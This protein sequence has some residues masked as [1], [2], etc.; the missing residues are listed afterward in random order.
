MT[1]AAAKADV[2]EVKFKPRTGRTHQLRITAREVWGRGIRWD[3]GYAV[4][5]EAKGVENFGVGREEEVEIKKIGGKVCALIAREWKHR[6]T[7]QVV[8]VRIGDLWEG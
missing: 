7:G 8:D 2:T 3:E 4:G 1:T 6:I 5:G